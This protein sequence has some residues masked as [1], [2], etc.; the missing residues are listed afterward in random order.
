MIPAHSS[1][2]KN[3]ARSLFSTAALLTVPIKEEKGSRP[4]NDEG[5]TMNDERPPRILSVHHS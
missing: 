1:Q 3:L 4:R 2:E 5:R